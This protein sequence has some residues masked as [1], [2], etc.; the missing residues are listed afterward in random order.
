MELFEYNCMQKGTEPLFGAAR[1]LPVVTE[2]QACE[3]VH[4]IAYVRV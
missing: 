2:L 1:T 4:W 3:V